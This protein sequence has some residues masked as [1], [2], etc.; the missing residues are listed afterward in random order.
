MKALLKSH[1]A[2]IYQEDLKQALKKI[3]LKQGDI[4]CVHSELFKLGEVLIP[5]KEFL[6][7]IIDIFFEI[8]GK[9]GTLIMPTF[10]YSFNRYKDYDKTYTKSTVG[11]LTEYF[12]ITMAA[13]GKGIRTNDPIFLF[14]SKDI[15]KINLKVNP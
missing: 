8:I 5:K 14:L 3:G 7:D 2:L 6:Q 15:I 4:L 1:K 10:T 13:E 9:K 12:R 11:I